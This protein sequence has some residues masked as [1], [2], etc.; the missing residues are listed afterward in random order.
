SALRR[1]SLHR[2]AAEDSIFEI[3]FDRSGMVFFYLFCFIFMLI[4]QLFTIDSWD[5]F[6]PQQ[7]GVLAVRNAHACEKGAVLMFCT[8][9]FVHCFKEVVIFEATNYALLFR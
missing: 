7:I 1:A 6:K 4:L 2:D 9:C 8:V 5:D 3:Q